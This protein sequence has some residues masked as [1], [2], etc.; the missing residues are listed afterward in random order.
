[1]QIEILHADRDAVDWVFE[2][3]ENVEMLDVYCEEVLVEAQGEI[4]K[5]PLNESAIDGWQVRAAVLGFCYDFGFRLALG[6]WKDCMLMNEE[7]IPLVLECMLLAKERKQ[8][9]GQ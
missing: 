1:M 7:V 3:F 5:V 4:E 6:W 9:G 8:G 2:D